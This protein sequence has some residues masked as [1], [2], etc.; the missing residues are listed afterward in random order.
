MFEESGSEQR[1]KIM[2]AEKHPL[3]VAIRRALF[4]E[5][6]LNY[7][8][9]LP[10]GFEVS[11]SSNRRTSVDRPETPGRKGEMVVAY[12]RRAPGTGREEAAGPGGC[13]A[14]LFFMDFS[15]LWQVAGL[16]EG[17]GKREKQGSRG[18]ALT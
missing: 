8:Q 12:A 7:S 18:P 3:V 4:L 9:P 16:E 1:S 17:V 15:E 13:G 2:R 6:S 14:G 10:T 5:S 11:L